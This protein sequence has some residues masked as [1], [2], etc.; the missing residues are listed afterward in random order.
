MTTEDFLAELDIA[1]KS[2]HK[3]SNAIA[4]KEGITNNPDF[5][6]LQDKIH[7]FC[8]TASHVAGQIKYKLKEQ[9]MNS[10]KKINKT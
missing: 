10:R 7:G 3:I 2:I 1:Y 9:T 8:N 4:S 5:Q 6:Y